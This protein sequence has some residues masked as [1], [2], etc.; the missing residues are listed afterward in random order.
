MSSDDA[1]P[2]SP[3]QNASPTS[4]EGTSPLLDVV[5]VLQQ[6]VV[7]V[8]SSF[9]QVYSTLAMSLKQSAEMAQSMNSVMEQFMQSNLKIRK[10]V[11]N[12]LTASNID[13]NVL[14]R[15][16]E[17]HGA[18]LV[19]TIV[20][21]GTF[22]IPNLSLSLKFKRRG[23]SELLDSIVVSRPTIDQDS[24]YK[25]FICL[26]NEPVEPFTL[27]PQQ[28]L[29]DTVE[30]VPDH[31]YQVG[32]NL[33]SDSYILMCSGRILEVQQ[34]T[35]VYLVDQMQ[36]RYP[37]NQVEVDSNAHEE[38]SRDVTLPLETLRSL[39]N[40][41]PCDGID[42]QTKFAFTTTFNTNNNI[43]ICG[44][45]EE[46]T[47]DGYKAKCKLAWMMNETATSNEFELIDRIV[48]EFDMIRNSR[49]L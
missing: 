33:L 46:I 27:V 2:K 49:H 20:N 10:V 39:L 21:T 19:I 5:N 41:R 45:V 6:S 26:A 42:K 16:Q 4:E 30:L 17:M 18:R 23:E 22:P 12:G 31:L 32:S 9:S 15:K 37:F 1:L 3:A 13:T 11:G 44:Q 38:H 36:T 28:K 43:G 29:T 8:Q 14:P 25:P 35:G 7:G 47:T 34:I 48:E 24:S 40:I